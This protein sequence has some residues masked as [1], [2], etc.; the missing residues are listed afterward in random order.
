MNL[1][2]GEVQSFV[3]SL[4]R[5][6]EFYAGVLGLH[7]TAESD[8]YLVFDIAGVEFIVMAGAA[9]GRTETT[10]GKQCA[11]VLCLRSRDIFSDYAELQKRGVQFLTDVV[12]AAPGMYYA[13]FQDPDGNLLELIQK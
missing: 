9:P 1:T 6:R 2:F 10:Y 4:A 3:S 7:L 12:E 8:D 5:A 11:T 13:P